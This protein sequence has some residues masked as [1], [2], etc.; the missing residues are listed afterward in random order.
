MNIIKIF[1]SLTFLTIIVSC[2][3][4]TFS[5][6]FENK[7]EYNNLPPVKVIEGLASFY[8]DKY[9]RQKTANGEVYDMFGLTA[10]SPDLPFDTILR[11]TNLKNNRSAI[12][13]VND[14]MPRHPERIID[15]S[16]GTAKKL[17]M[18][19]DGVVWIKLEILEWGK[20][21]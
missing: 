14:R 9:H 17:D 4:A 13:R 21:D 15:L 8:A 19:E 1:S 5:D 3:S 18:V 20:T 16:Y 7:Q 12:I 2:S 6:R 11:V 10:A